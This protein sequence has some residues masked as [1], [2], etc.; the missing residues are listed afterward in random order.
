MRR[1]F[2][3]PTQFPR[4]ANLDPGLSSDLS[5]L[6]SAVQ[7]LADD[8]TYAR[9]FETTLANG[10]VTLALDKVTRLKPPTSGAVA[11]LLPASALSAENH[12][13]ALV[14]TGTS[15]ATLTIL[16]PK[17]TT[18]DGSASLTVSAVP[19]MHWFMLHGGNWYSAEVIARAAAIIAAAA[20]V[21]ADAALALA[22]AA[23]KLPIVYH[24][25]TFSPILLAQFNGDLTDSSGNGHD[26]SGASPSYS[27]IHPGVIGL[28]FRAT[29]ATVTTDALA[30]T[31][32]LTVE[33]IAQVDWP[34]APG[35]IVA[36]AGGSNQAYSISLQTPGLGI[37][38][39][40]GGGHTGVTYTEATRQIRKGQLCHFA[41]TRTSGVVQFYIN[42]KAAGAASGTLT[43]PDAVTGGTLTI[44]STGANGTQGVICSL[45]VIGSA[46]SAADVLAE[47]NRTLGPWFG[48]RT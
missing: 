43:A 13:A 6:G 9:I 41:V 10:S 3:I 31:G 46:L 27:E 7:Q 36:Y 37:F 23:A 45:K 1:A 28:D 11:L 19:G 12:F 25:T 2:D 18:V 26:M 44:G 34:P 39:Q 30:L 8:P 24:D 4:P 22:T 47:Y 33:F 5:R 20:K 17:G 35:N 32:D 48:T 14:V 38:W 16:P 15:V 29:T 21:T 40:H 42:G